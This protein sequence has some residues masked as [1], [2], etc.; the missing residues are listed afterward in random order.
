MRA[1]STAL[2]TGSLLGLAPRARERTR[3]A[4]AR[5]PES[6]RVGDCGG[7]PSKGYVDTGPAGCK[8]AVARAPRQI[9][10]AGTD[11]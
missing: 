2:P 8:G 4:A 11:G 3:P 6:A 9:E 10:E 5:S 1:T 7:C